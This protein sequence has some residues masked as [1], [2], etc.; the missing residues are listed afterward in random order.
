MDELLKQL[1]SLPLGG[2]RYYECIGSTNEVACEWAAQGAP[3]L[4]LVV[5]DEQTTGRG[6]AGRRWFTPPGAGLAFSVILCPTSS[7]QSIL[8]LTALGALAV[9]DALYERYQLVTQI[10]WPN[11]VLADGRKLAGVLVEAQWQGEEL[12][13]AVLGI[14]IN[15]A[16]SSVPNAEDLHF[17][18]TCVEAVLGQSVA[19]WDLLHAVIQ[20]LI[21]WLPRLNSPDFLQ[22]WEQRLAYRDQWVRISDKQD[23]SGTGSEES[24]IEGILLGLDMDGFLK[25]QTST[26]NII[27]VQYGDVHLRP[28]TPA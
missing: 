4:S 14:G 3:N 22:S 12:L 26:G 1:A 19:R 11:D 6:R 5:A 2:L 23:I 24:S 10:K 20:A 28:K 21:R 27:L 13:S 25:L 18:A 7:V 17:P 15:V 9:S 16:S 8:R